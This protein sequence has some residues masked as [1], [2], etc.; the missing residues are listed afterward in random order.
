MH[1]IIE[2]KTPKEDTAQEEQE[3]A[4]DEKGREMRN[5]SLMRRTH[6]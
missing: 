3:E 5:R 2:H 4:G 1:G 6:V